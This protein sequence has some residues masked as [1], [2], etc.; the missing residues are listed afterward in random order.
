MALTVAR[1]M[2]PEAA[3]Q[4]RQAL[5]SYFGDK[6][7]AA[8]LGAQGWN[9][10]LDWPS[11]ADWYVDPQLEHG[12]RWWGRGTVP[13]IQAIPLERRRESGIALSLF[14]TWTLHAW[15]EWLQRHGGC[16]EALILHVDDHLDLGSPRLFV[17]SDGWTDAITGAPF[18]LRRPSTVAAA[19]E[20]GAVS[21]GTFL[22]PMV[23]AVERIEIRHLRPPRRG[24]DTV[25]RRLL[26]TTEVDALLSP[27]GLRPAVAMAP[28][29]A[30]EA[31]Q[32]GKVYRATC[33]VDEWLRDAPQ[34]PVLLHIDM[35]FFCNRFDGDSDWTEAPDRHDTPLSDVLA[36]IDALFATLHASDVADRLDGVAVGVSPG[37]FPAEFWEAAWKRIVG[38]VVARSPF[39]GQ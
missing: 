23:H 26:P 1:H 7:A 35:D 30:T 20:S 14:D 9:L 24:R 13:D 2:L 34:W 28:L 18:D 10:T 25:T 16:R 12:L 17:G 4:R 37:F 32:G 39:H 22:T 31:G 21:M 8:T 5:R 33:A 36:G 38:N 19:I 27:G 3:E 11:E 15:S 29:G 6:E